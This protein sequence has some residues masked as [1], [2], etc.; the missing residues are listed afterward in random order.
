M[1]ARS[2]RQKLTQNTIAVVF[3]FMHPRCWD[4][5]IQQ[6]ALKS[7]LYETVLDLTMLAKI[8]TRA[9]LN[10]TGG[11][12]PDW[13]T[14]YVGAEQFSWDDELTAPIFRQEKEGHFLA[15]DPGLSLGFDGLLAN[16]PLASA[17]D[18]APKNKFIDNGSDIFS[19]IPEE[20]LSEIA[21]LL[22]S[23]SVRN[24]QFASRRMASLHLSSRYWRSRFNFPNELCHVN[25]PSGLLSFGQVG[26]LS[27]DWR[28][29]CD[30]LLHPLG[31]RYGWWEN[32]KRV[33][34]L[35]SKLVESMSRRRIDG[36]LM[37]VDEVRSLH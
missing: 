7:S 29:L 37:E 2:P 20:I 22:P 18:I 8:F 15:R 33:A 3:Y 24:L 27:I 16:P 32:R 10:R 35:N 19:R 1:S 30:Q 36:S 14:D 21:V 23:A 31:E 26:D 6:H 17:T 12:K 34:A 9:P 13:T 25:L 11:F 5:L 4:K 28:R